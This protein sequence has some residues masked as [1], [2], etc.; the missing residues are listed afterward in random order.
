M[1][2]FTFQTSPTI[3]FGAGA[4]SRI[5]GLLKDYKAAHVLLV[6]D[7]GVRAAG[8][9]RNAEVAIAE[10]GIALTVFDGVVADPPS[11]VIEAATA[12]CREHGCDAV[13]SIGG[14]SALDTAKL[15]AYL[16]KTPEKLDDVYGIGLATG[17]RLP[18]LLV[19]TTAGTGSEAT[20]V[21]VVTTPTNEKKAV[22]SSRLIPDWAVLDPVL[23]LRLPPDVTAQTG[24]D[25]M[26]HAIEAYTGKIKKNP[27]SDLFALQA[28]SLLAPN[29]RKVY[30]DGS[31]L[32]ARSA[33]HLGSVLA[34][35]AFANSPV[36]AVHAFAYPIGALFHVPHGLSNAL[37]LPDVL[38]FNRPAA[39]TLYAELS[40]VIQPGYRRQSD[41]ADAA[42]FIAEIKAICR[43]CG[44]PSSL[45]AVGIGEDDL[46]KLTEDAMKQ[47]RLLDNNPR[48][49]DYRQARAIY[50]SA[51]AGRDPATDAGAG[52]APAFGGPAGILPDPAAHHGNV[53]QQ[54]GAST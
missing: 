29:I 39:E 28:L 3:L 8:L 36:A 13:V 54:H 6:T 31:D 38:E 5:A 25:A 19:P 10:A 12:I 22:V 45:S 16:A 2:A 33:M 44:V 52:H 24:I 42:A 46:S 1:K 9:T 11:H 48:D 14:G 32:E 30:K 27:I 15:V 37:I 18:L 49:L 34:G 53:A 50:A 41:A 17:E 26:V 35:M 23:T 43:D 51:L 7:K 4:S 20:P 47:K 21:A 40:E